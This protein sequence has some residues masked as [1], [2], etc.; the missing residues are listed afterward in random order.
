M[1]ESFKENRQIKYKGNILFKLPYKFHRGCAVIYNNRL[2]I[3][4][5]YSFEGYEGTR[6]YSWDGTSWRWESTLPYSFDS[7]S[8][9]VYNGKIHILGGVD[10]RRNH[11]VWDGTTAN[12]SSHWSS[13]ATLPMD[14]Y[15][16][17]LV[18]NNELQALGLGQNSVN[19][20]Y[21]YVFNGTTWQQASI[22]KDTTY[23][24]VAENVNW[25]SSCIVYNNSIYVMS[26]VRA[27]KWNGTTWARTTTDFRNSYASHPILYNNYIYYI[28]GNID[29]RFHYELEGGFIEKSELTGTTVDYL[30]RGIPYSFHEGAVVEYNANL[31]LIGG[32]K[33]PYA[34]FNLSLSNNFI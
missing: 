28:G 20:Y 3:L 2:H 32:E 30:H 12:D 11:Y 10:N 5:G 33:S 6:H 26:K 14:F 29:E 34:L 18:Y 21:H 9:V 15:G 31:Y 4:G 27:L 23:N 7:G 16:T 13:V 19:N 25:Y 24:E 17:A 1:Y 22:I 8:A